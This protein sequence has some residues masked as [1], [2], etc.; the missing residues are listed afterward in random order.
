MHEGSSQAARTPMARRPTI[1]DLAAKAGVSVAT[2][3]RV[4]NARTP[5]RTETARRVHEAAAAIGYHAAGLLRER[6]RAELPFVRLG[7]LLQRPD[8]AFFQAFGRELLAACEGARDIRIRPEVAF[9]ESQQPAEVAPR[10]AALGA[11]SD[12]VAAVA[13]EHPA[14]DAVVADL[15]ARGVRVFALV[16]DFA[17]GARDGYLGLDNRKVGRTAAWTIA[18]IAPAPGKVA[19]FVGSHRFLGHEMREIGFRTFF[20]E[21]APD[22]TV[23]DTLVNL[24][25]PALAHEATLGLLHRHPD[26]AGLYVA[27]GGM[28]GVIA[29][30]R[31]EGMAGR[32]VAVCNESTADTRAALADGIMTLVVATPLERLCRELVA[33]M[34]RALRD[35]AADATVFLP[36]DILVAENI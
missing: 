29:A 9:L 4:L 1:T 35:G 11:R 15:K 16:S 5:V 30:L 34:T 25:T 28:E 24:E 10:L 33:Q 7:F 18:R 13:I 6:L 14:V 23:L 19:L 22:F 21:A 2:V 12:A 27:G 17:P 32:L 3:D 8:Q 31:E 36:F 26:L 20:R